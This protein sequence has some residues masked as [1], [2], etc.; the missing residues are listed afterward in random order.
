MFWIVANSLSEAYPI[1]GHAHRN[2]I[3]LIQGDRFRSGVAT[4]WRNL[5]WKSPRQSAVI[6]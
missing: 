6:E 2:A 5:L 4:S 1:E 3:D